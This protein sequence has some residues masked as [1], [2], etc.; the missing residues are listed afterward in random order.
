[1]LMYQIVQTRAPHTRNR[2]KFVDTG[3]G[4]EKR[5]DWSRFDIGNVLR[6]LKTAQNR[7]TLQREGVNCTFV[8]GMLVKQL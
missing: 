7:S 8:G 1:M 5:S 2:R 4:T 6:V 3:E